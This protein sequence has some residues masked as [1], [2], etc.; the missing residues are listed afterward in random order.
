MMTR[1]HWVIFPTDFLFLSF[2]LLLCVS[3]WRHRYEVKFLNML[4]TL[5]QRPLVLTAC[6]L[7][8]MYGII[9][10]LDSIHLQKQGHIYSVLDHCLSPLN[11]FYEKT[12]S[13]PMAHY[14]AVKSVR[15]DAAT[16]RFIQYYPKLRY[17]ASSTGSV[18]SL[19]CMA[20][21]RAVLGLSILGICAYVCYQ[22][23]A[24]FKKFCVFCQKNKFAWRTALGCVVISGLLCSVVQVLLQHYHL[25]GTDKVGQDV[26]YQSLK[27]IRTAF[28][29]G[30]LTSFILLP[31]AIS[32]GI[33]AGYLGKKTDD[34]IQ[35]LYTVISSVPGILLIAASFLSLQIILFRHEAWFNSGLE[36]AECKLLLLCFILG[37]T[38]WTNLCRLIR[39][40]TL[41]LKTMDYVLAAR[42]I[43][44][45]TPMILRQHIFPNL[46]HIVIIA[47]AID[48]SSLILSEAILSY[49]GIGVD[50][51]LHSWGLM[52]NAARLELA[53]EPVVWWPLMS[54]FLMMFILV[55]ST[56][57]IADFLRDAL[58][59]KINSI[60]N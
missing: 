44:T 50:P 17:T 19:I 59:P 4:C 7:F 51:S 58:D 39:A 1:Y 29:V 5:L 3:F 33:C 6:F 28:I 21:L 15:F 34:L 18:C 8:M 25:L 10:I 11:V 54:A 35:Y 36:R 16:A 31:V 49:V 37:L 46:V 43:G 55:F 13:K 38:S 27:G 42:T 32:L 22:R 9:A 2:I 57:I 20:C 60:K 24:V 30:F 40:E 53:R 56:N 26:F 41:K 52:I 12:Y 47:T 23:I 48:F 14:S 45:S